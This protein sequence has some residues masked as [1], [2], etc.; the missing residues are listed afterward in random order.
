MITGS[1]LKS[2]KAHLTRVSGEELLRLQSLW[3]VD[4]GHRAGWR[5][6]S[7]KAE[8]NKRLSLR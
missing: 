1:Q 8:L 3:M 6:E 4:Q 2:Y 7:I 5:V